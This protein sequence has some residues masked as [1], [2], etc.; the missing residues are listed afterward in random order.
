MHL[1]YTMIQFPFKQECSLN[2]DKWYL[3]TKE[4]LRQLNNFRKKGEKDLY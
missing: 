1:E 2:K 4:S 3:Y